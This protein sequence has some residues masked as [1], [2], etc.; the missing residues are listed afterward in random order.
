MKGKYII[1]FVVFIFIILL[2][3]SYNYNKGINRL[4]N[5][6]KE[7]NVYRE[8][9]VNSKNI[10]H[11]EICIRAYNDLVSNYNKEFMRF[12]NSIIYARL[13]NY[14]KMQYWNDNRN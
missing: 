3:Q 6:S 13:G 7:M 4:I 12:P 5:L 1:F 2:F 11:K 9:I 8:K 10:H 14:D